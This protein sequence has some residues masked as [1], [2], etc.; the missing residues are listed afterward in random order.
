MQ[1]NQWYFAGYFQKPYQTDKPTDDQLSVLIRLLLLL[2]RKLKFADDIKWL[3]MLE[4]QLVK[5]VSL[6]F[7]GHHVV[8]STQFSMNAG[9]IV[10]ICSIN[11]TGKAID[12]SYSVAISDCSIEECSGSSYRILLHLSFTFTILWWNIYNI[13]SVLSVICVKICE[14]M[15]N[16]PCNCTL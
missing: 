9:Y 2:S 16:F 12:V 7:N 5:C 4:F 14:A 11:C 8:S 6:H 10:Y 15:V 13:Y 1:W 3:S